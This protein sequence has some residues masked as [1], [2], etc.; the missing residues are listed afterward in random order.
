MAN[1]GTPT[2]Q[3]EVDIGSYSAQKKAGTARFIKLNGQPFYSYRQF[4]PATGD[5]VSLNVPVD[6]DALVDVITR[7]NAQLDS[8]NAAIASAQ[9]ALADLDAAPEVLPAA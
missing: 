7:Q 4:D 5:P 9:E 2:P 1:I 8:I 6:R 3:R